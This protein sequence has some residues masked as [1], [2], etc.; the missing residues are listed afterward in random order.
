M[1][2]ST[3]A[4]VHVVL[5]GPRGRSTDLM[6]TDCENH[7]I[8]FQQG[9]EDIFYVTCSYVGDLR[10]IQIGHDSEGRTISPSVIIKRIHYFSANLGLYLLLLTSCIFL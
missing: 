9:A 10:K 6:L 5:Y 1:G 7:K 4:N 2:A 8:P 3:K